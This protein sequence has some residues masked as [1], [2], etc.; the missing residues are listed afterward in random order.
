M[1]SGKNVQDRAKYI[2]AEALEIRRKQNGYMV[3]EALDHLCN[4]NEQIS[5]TAVTIAQEDQMST[6]TVA[7]EIT[8]RPSTARQTRIC[9]S[10]GC[11]NTLSYNNVTGKCESCRKHSSQ[12]TNGH[13]G[14]QPH[15]ELQASP[16]HQAAPAKRNGNGA[17]H[18]PVNGNGN[19]HGAQTADRE[20]RVDRIFAL[21]TPIIPSEDKL[22][23]LAVYLEQL[24]GHGVVDRSR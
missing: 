10:A 23:I 6:S 14:A 19:G 20:S 4:H 9:S 2:L 3:T 7:S 12:K 18:H 17:A 8:P 22:K 24:A 5:P 16:K 13:N 1:A 15:R 11:P 21:I